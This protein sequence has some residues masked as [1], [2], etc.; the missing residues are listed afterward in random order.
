MRSDLAAA[1]LAA[2]VLSACGNL[3]RPFQPDEKA[4]DNPLL[5][6]PDGAGVVVLPPAGLGGDEARALAAALVAALQAENV[7]ASP[8]PGNAASHVLAARGSGEGLVTLALRTPRGATV[9]EIVVPM[10]PARD[11]AR[12]NAVTGAVARDIAAALQPEAVAPK[13]PRAVAIGPVT[14][15]AAGDGLTLARALD[16]AL[17]RAGVRIADSADRDSLVVTAAVQV[18]PRAPGTR[19]VRVEWTMRAPDGSEVGQIRQENEVP[20]DLVERGWPE[21]A[22]AVA[23]GAAE[24]IA[25][26]IERAPAARRAGR[27]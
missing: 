9:R 26:L 27:P 12:L 8:R 23:D 5:A 15:R 16:F 10:P 3:P 1:V 24:G 7:P 17:R 21:L 4:A 6:L 22:A 11:R 20:A 19:Q 14:G 13:P 25:D 18:A 2:A